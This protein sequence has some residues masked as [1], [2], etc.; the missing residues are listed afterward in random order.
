MNSA[1]KTELNGPER[2]KAENDEDRPGEARYY[3]EAI[4]DEE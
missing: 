3:R 4:V 1:T 2:S